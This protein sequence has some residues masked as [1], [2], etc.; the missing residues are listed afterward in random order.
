MEQDIWDKMTDSKK[1]TDME[2]ALQWAFHI[3]NPCT[4]EV[5]GRTENIREFYLRESR[6]HVIPRLTNPS[7]VEF[8]QGIIDKYN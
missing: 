2:I 4:V 1:L 5:R 7:A 8:L 3:E 6:E